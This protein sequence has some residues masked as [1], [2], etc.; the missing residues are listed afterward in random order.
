MKTS[1]FHAAVGNLVSKVSGRRPEDVDPDFNV[2]AYFDPDAVKDSALAAAADLLAEN[3]YLDTSEP[4]E[5][6]LEVLG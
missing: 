6:L 4:V 5:A 1:S 2:E 3:G